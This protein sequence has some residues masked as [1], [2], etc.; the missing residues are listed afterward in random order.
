MS[1][2]TFVVEFE[3]GKE[4]LV[5][6]TDNF[7]G[8]GGR[9]CSAAMYDYK[10]DNFTTEQRDLISAAMEEFNWSGDISDEAASAIM[11]KVELLTQ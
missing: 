11:D 6:F 4:P 1:R 7:M 3:D 5:S 8:S 10:D 2:M 9:L